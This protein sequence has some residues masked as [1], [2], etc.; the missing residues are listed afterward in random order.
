VFVLPPKTVPAQNAEDERVVWS[1]SEKA[2]LRSLSIAS[3]PPLPADPSNGVADDRRAARLGQRLFFDTRLSADNQVSCAS[4][5]LPDLAFTDGRKLGRGVGTAGRNTMTILGSAYSPWLFWDGRKDS[6]WSQALG[7]TESAVE[8]GGTRTQFA[9]LIASDPALKARYES[10]FGSLPDLGD[11]AR[12]PAAAGPVED[13]KARTAWKAMAPADRATVSAVFANIGKA[14]AAYERRLIPGPARF[15][16]YVAAVLDGD[17]NAAREI[18]TDTEE[19]GLRVFIGRGQCTRCHNGPLLSNFTFHNTG[20]PPRP[21]TQ[22]DKGR[23]V[24]VAQA[25]EDPFNCLGEFSDAGARDCGELRFAKTSGADLVGAMKTPSLRNISKTA[26][27]M[28][29]GQYAT[30][31]PA[32]DHYNRAPK[33][34]VGTSELSPLGLGADELAA[35]EWFLLTLDSPPALERTDLTPPD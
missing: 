16:R 22:P 9:R 3:L 4:C 12:F 26:P 18:F 30:L 14:I 28:H 13:A 8:H 7:P 25:L 27:Y 33:A 2:V 34:A 23:S 19:E 17:D 29:A 31:E 11:S 24:G 32:L 15:D 20:V 5:H 1:D 35:L 21:G 6:L 10:L